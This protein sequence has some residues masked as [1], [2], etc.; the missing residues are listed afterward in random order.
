[1][2][3]TIIEDHPS[4]IKNALDQLGLMHVL[5]IIPTIKKAKKYLID[6]SKDA[7][8]KP[9]AILID[10]ML[11]VTPDPKRLAVIADMEHLYEEFSHHTI[12]GPDEIKDAIA[13]MNEK[14]KVQ[15]NRSDEVNREIEALNEKLSRCQR[16]LFFEN[17]I[18]YNFILKSI[19]LRINY[20]GLC[21]GAAHASPPIGVCSSQLFY[22]GDV[23]YQSHRQN[24]EKFKTGSSSVI[25]GETG[26]QEFGTKI[27]PVKRWDWL[28]ND[29]VEL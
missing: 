10:C 26:Y 8:Y 17:P 1:M 25:I 18:G 27:F 4:N 22:D 15:K 23:N 29:L 24:N 16:D 7:S 13:K 6:L 21:K 9:D 19:S 14:K 11:P 12:A 2:N 20:I 3:I 28:L 5:R